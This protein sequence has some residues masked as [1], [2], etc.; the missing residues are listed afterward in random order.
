MMKSDELEFLSK[1]VMDER[2]RIVM[3]ELSI[4]HDRRNVTGLPVNLGAYLGTE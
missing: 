4:P 3:I 1:S 2:N